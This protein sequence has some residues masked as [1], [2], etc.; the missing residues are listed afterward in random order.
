M[1]YPGGTGGWGWLWTSPSSGNCGGGVSG[2]VTTFETIQQIP[3]E[4][5]GKMVIPSSSASAAQ[6][7]SVPTKNNYELASTSNLV[8]QEV[9]EEIKKGNKSERDE[10][11]EKRRE[12]NRLRERRRRE[13]M[14]LEER[15]KQREQNR[16]RARRRRLEEKSDCPEQVDFWGLLNEDERRRLERERE[17]R[18]LGEKRR[19]ERKTAEEREMVKERHRVQERERRRNMS[20]VEKE[21]MRMRNRERAKQRRAEMSKEDRDKWKEKRRL[22]ERKRR[23][24]SCAAGT[25]A[26]ASSC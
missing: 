22:Q 25:S 10:E 14:T 11:L 20:E 3:R 6:I 7:I 19:R 13:L 15:V 23:G 12:A 18:R 24:S 26:A 2:T 5:K 16:E 17:V 4:P 8:K 1:E 9:V 21:E